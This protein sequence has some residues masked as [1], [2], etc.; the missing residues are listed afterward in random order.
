MAIDYEK[1]K[2]VAVISFNNPKQA[3]VLDKV[4]SYEISE[5]WKEVWRDPDI[6]AIILTGKGDRHFCAG[7]NLK[8]RPDVTEEER[9][10]LAT[11][12]IF[13]PRFGSFFGK[14]GIDGRMGDHYPRIWKPVIAAVNG[15]AAGA[16]FYILLS[17]TDI[18]I[19]SKENARFKFALL[20]NGWVG[21]G[22]GATLLTR[23]LRYADAMQVLLTDEAFGA[24]EA[25]RIGLINEV[26]SHDRLL[27]RA[28]EIAE[29]IAK[30]P[31]LATRMMKEFVIRFGEI[32]TDAAWQVQT[33]MNN[34]LI[35]TTADGSEGKQAFL[36]KREPSFTGRL[37]QKGDAYPDPDQEQIDRYN[38]IIRSSETLSPDEIEELDERFRP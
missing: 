9:E 16:G 11:N 28:H 5:A 20:S 34:L 29:K 33:L 12:G 25:L 10:Y 18:R 21:G 6:R 13:W 26:V 1:Q 32:P 15:W 4:T 3:N 7:H 24:D 31:P 36:E 2:H 30:M 35:Q 37:R 38:E 27:D 19:A 23:Q 14:P 8:P 17:S 22:P